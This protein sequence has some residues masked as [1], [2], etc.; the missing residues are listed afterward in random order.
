MN[1]N[2]RDDPAVQAR[3]NRVRQISLARDGNKCT[4]C[5]STH[6]LEVHHKWSWKHYP[7]Y[8]FDAATHITLCRYCHKQYHW[9]MGGSWRKC[10]PIHYNKWLSTRNSAAILWYLNLMMYGI[11]ILLTT[12]A[13]TWILLK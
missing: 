2:K 12:G 3:W 4:V 5:S 1:S 8:R 6:R 13:L 11:I 10:T 7:K 9:W